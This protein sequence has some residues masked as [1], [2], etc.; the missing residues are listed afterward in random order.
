MLRVTEL[1]RG[2]G[3]PG[4]GCSSY[5]TGIKNAVLLP[6]LKRSTAGGCAVPFRVLSRKNM[7]E[8]IMYWIH[9]FFFELVPVRSEKHFKPHPQDG[10]LV[11]LRESYQN[12]PRPF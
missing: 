10:I 7:T 2:R 3:L 9:Y 5:L 11:P 12:F 8:D 1:E 4:Q 6:R